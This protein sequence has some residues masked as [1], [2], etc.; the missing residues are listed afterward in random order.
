MQGESRK[1]GA[2]AGPAQPHPPHP[3][4]HSTPNPST[5]PPVPPFDPVVEIGAF[6]ARP[7]AQVALLDALIAGG[8]LGHARLGQLHLR[9]GE[10]GFSFGRWQE[11]FQRLFLEICTLCT[12]E[13]LFSVSYTDGFC[14]RGGGG[15]AWA[16]CTAVQQQGARTAAARRCLLY[17]TRYMSSF[18]SLHRGLRDFSSTSSIAAVCILWGK[19][20]G[21]RCRRRHPAVPSA[22]QKY[23]PTPMPLLGAGQRHPGHG[24][25]L[26]GGQCGGETPAPS[27]ARE[28]RCAEKAQTSALAA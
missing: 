18:V 23:L 2:A 22:G 20:E 24:G 15:N 25:E 28:S 14:G 3:P 7:H 6:D 21:E 13:S 19:R 8:A 5:H 1:A 10:C 16:C 9:A 26:T 27:E 12:G 17:R 11:L 4:A